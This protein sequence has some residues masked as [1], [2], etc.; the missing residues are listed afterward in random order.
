M[1]ALIDMTGRICGHLTV[2][3]LDSMDKKW[4]QALW[5]CK[6]SCGEEKIVKG[7]ALRDGNTKSCGCHGKILYRI[8]EQCGIKKH[9][10]KFTF[11]RPT[12]VYRPVCQECIGSDQTRKCS[13]CGVQKLISEFL[14]SKKTYKYKEIC[15]D[16]NGRRVVRETPGRPISIQREKQKTD[17][18][19]AK[20]LRHYGGKCACCGENTPVF[21][22]IDHLANNGNQHR[23]DGDRRR[24]SRIG[25]WLEKNGYPEGF[26]VLCNNCNWAKHVNELCPHQIDSAVSA[27]SMGG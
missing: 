13:D 25:S 16:C 17:A 12:Q 14:F 18:Q 4:G 22:A 26:Q 19:R 9:Q 3:G 27:L 1:A 5:N 20:A 23:Y 21:L 24:F 2:I 7:Q 8:C 6:C 11:S 15:R 10:S